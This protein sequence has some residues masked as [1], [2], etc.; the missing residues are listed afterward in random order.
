MSN[1]V[2]SLPSFALSVRQPWAWAIIHA[3]KDIENRSW[4]ATNP[5]RQ[6]RGRVAVHASSGL[7]RAEYEDAREWLQMMGYPCPEASD[8]LRGG[9]I[10]SVRVVDVVGHSKSSWFHGPI[11]LVL[12]DPQPVAFIP[13]K[14]ALGYFEWQPGRPGDV[15]RPAQWMSSAPRQSVTKP[16]EPDLFSAATV[17]RASGGGSCG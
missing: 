4:Q 15:P 11:G 16:P 1:P 6:V 14:G 3:G 10:G 8:L 13:A 7:T 17:A 12:R 9:I 2:N 5:A